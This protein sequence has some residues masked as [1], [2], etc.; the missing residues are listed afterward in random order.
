MAASGPTTTAADGA[1][2]DRINRE[3]RGYGAGFLFE[4]YFR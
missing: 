1:K 3:A 2:T 4:G